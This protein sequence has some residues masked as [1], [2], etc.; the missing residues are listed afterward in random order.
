[1]VFDEDQGLGLQRQGWD[2]LDVGQG[3]VVPVGD[4]GRLVVGTEL[5]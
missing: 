1:M 5:A 4:V 2:R 3:P